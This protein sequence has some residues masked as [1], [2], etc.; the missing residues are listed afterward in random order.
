MKRRY[1][2]PAAGLTLGGLCAWMFL[3]YYGF[4]G[5]LLVCTGAVIF[6][7]G[8]ADAM[9]KRFPTAVRLLNCVMLGLAALI[10]LA[11]V[12]T[13]GVVV[14]CSS[15]AEEPEAAYLI[16]LGA[17]VNG[18]EPSL[19]LA[20]RLRAAKEY[21]EMYPDAIAVLSGGQGDFEQI[22]EAEC[23]YRWLTSA[24]ISAERLRKEDA[25]TNTEENIACSLALIEEEFGERP[26]CVAVVSSE[27]HLCRASLL[28]ERVGVELLGVPA[29][30]TN[31]VYYV[32]MLLREITGVWYTLLF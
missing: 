3:D 16:V 19:S 29:R 17:G 9:K 27:Y 25:A 7:F 22:S 21:L 5:I 24:G 30:T 11:G 31:R 4:A 2:L 15:G 10:L 14:K 8:A 12:V 18:T 23:M 1:F 26:T 6:A 32:Q 13:G 28:A 20:E